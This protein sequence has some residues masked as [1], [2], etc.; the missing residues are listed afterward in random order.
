MSRRSDLNDR[1]NLNWSLRTGHLPSSMVKMGSKTGRQQIAIANGSRRRAKTLYK[2]VANA[3]LVAMYANHI[4][5]FVI[6]L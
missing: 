5:L 1:P 4:I 2:P 6:D 3:V